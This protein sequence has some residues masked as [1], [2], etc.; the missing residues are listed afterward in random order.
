MEPEAGAIGRAGAFGPV[1]GG[2]AEAVE[3]VPEA[4][5]AAEDVPADGDEGRIMKVSALSAGIQ[6]QSR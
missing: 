4:A 3:D 2:A 6:C 5:E 1:V